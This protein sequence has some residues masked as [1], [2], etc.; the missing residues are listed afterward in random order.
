M[1][2]FG[3]TRLPGAARASRSATG[4]G[5]PPT[6]GFGSIWT[7][8]ADGTVW[9]VE[10]KTGRV[11]AIVR[12]GGLPFGLAVGEGAV[13]VANH[14]DGTVSRIDPRTE[15]IVATIETGFFPE[16]LART[17]ATCGS[18]SR[19]PLGLRRTERTRTAR[20]LGGRV[21]WRPMTAPKRFPDR[22]EI[23]AVRA[24]AEPLEAGREGE[25]TRRLAGRAMA[26]RE[27]G[28]LVFLDLVDR[29]GRIQVICD[30]AV[31]GEIDVRLG[32]V[33]GVVGRA[34]EVATRRA[35]RPRGERRGPLA[36]HAAAARTRSTGSRTSSCATAS[37]T[38]TS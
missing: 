16:W 27:M 36:Q 19:Q 9:R 14:E 3:S 6:G 2:C 11:R 30:L 15:R 8:A 28:K 21:G 25:T 33:V 38:S 18:G 5:G 10:A 20:R 34:G 4:P 23:A 32:D 37:A 29:S 22:D 7:T 35:V 24:E 17:I 13:W 26:R 31:T 12:V 1:S